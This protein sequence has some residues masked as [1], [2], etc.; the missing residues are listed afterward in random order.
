MTIYVGI[1]HNMACWHL[2]ELGI[3][4]TQAVFVYEVLWGGLQ[5]VALRPSLVFICFEILENV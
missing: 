3:F 4:L 5:R 1:T 2:K